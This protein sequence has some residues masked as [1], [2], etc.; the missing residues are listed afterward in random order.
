MLPVLVPWVEIPYRPPPLVYVVVVASVV[1]VVVNLFV[2][3]YVFFRQVHEPH[4]AWSRFHLRP[5]IERPRDQQATATTTATSIV[6]IC[7]GSQK[8]MM[9][10]RCPSLLRSRTGALEKSPWVE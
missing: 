2:A 4:L 3:T 10:S 5:W 6:F 1:V 8:G 9:P 7:E